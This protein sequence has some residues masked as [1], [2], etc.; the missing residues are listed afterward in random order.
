MI[1]YY[2]IGFTKLALEFGGI[3]AKVG[4]G[5]FL[6]RRKNFL[7]DRLGKGIGRAR[8]KIYFFFVFGLVAATKTLFKTNEKNYTSF[9]YCR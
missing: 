8:N 2:C 5:A 1:V 3:L 9:I 7:R 6:I 4:G